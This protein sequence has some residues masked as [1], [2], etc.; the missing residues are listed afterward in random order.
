MR[1]TR[2]RSLIFPKIKQLLLL[3]ISWGYAETQS[4]QNKVTI[5]QIN[6]LYINDG[7]EYRFD[8]EFQ[9]DSSAVFNISF[10]PPMP[11]HNPPIKVKLFSP[12]TMAP[13]QILLTYSDQISCKDG[14]FLTPVEFIVFCRQNNGSQLIIGNLVRK[15]QAAIKQA[16]IVP[17]AEPGMTCRDPLV[18]VKNDFVTGIVY[19]FYIIPCFRDATGEAADLAATQFK[20]IY[21]DDHFKVIG[22]FSY[23]ASELSITKKGLNISD[24]EVI[25]LG[26]DVSLDE[27]GFNIP[28]DQLL[29]SI[30]LYSKKKGYFGNT[31]NLECVA[32]NIDYDSKILAIK[33]YKGSSVVINNQLKTLETPMVEIIKL[34][35][36]KVSGE[37]NLFYYMF[38]VN[39][40]PSN[41]IMIQA[42]RFLKN[43]GSNK[44]TLRA[45]NQPFSLM[46][47]VQSPYSELEFA[48]FSYP[49]LFYIDQNTLGTVSLKI[50]S[51][52]S[53]KKNKHS[54]SD[55]FSSTSDSEPEYN[56]SGPLTTLRSYYYKIVCDAYNKS[57]YDF[58]RL[59][60]G[61]Q[62]L[63]LVYTH[64]SH[65]HRT[66]AVIVDRVGSNLISQNCM[67]SRMAGFTMFNG[68]SKLFIKT[69]L[70]SIVEAY[71]LSSGSIVVIAKN[72]T[73]DQIV[74][75][76]ITQESR[77][78]Q[79]KSIELQFTVT[80]HAYT[81][82]KIDMNQTTMDVF[83]DSWTQIPIE[84]D[85]LFG[86]DARIS[87]EGL[88]YPQTSVILMQ[89]GQIECSFSSSRGRGPGGIL[90]TRNIKYMQILTSS[91][92]LAST[93]GR[94]GVFRCDLED[95]RLMSTLCTCSLILTK[96]I[97]DSKYAIYGELFHKKFLAVAVSNKP[98][99]PRTSKIFI[100][101]LETKQSVLV[102]NNTG[103]DFL[104]ISNQKGRFLVLE[105]AKL[106]GV[107]MVRYNS[108]TDSDNFYSAMFKKKKL[109]NGTMYYQLSMFS[110][111]DF[112]EENL[113]SKNPQTR[114]H[115]IREVYGKSG[116]FMVAMKNSYNG[117][118]ILDFKV[119]TGYYC[120]ANF[121]A[122]GCLETLQMWR[123]PYLDSRLD[124]DIC[125]MSKDV[126]IIPRGYRAT[127]HGLTGRIY[128]YSIPYDKEPPMVASA[129]VM[130]GYPFKSI[131]KAILDAT[132]YGFLDTFQIL[133]QD[134][135]GKK[136]IIS[137]RNSMDPRSR[138]SRIDM[139]NN[140]GIN[141]V[142]I[143]GEYE[144]KFV[145][146]LP[147][148]NTATDSKTGM[149]LRGNSWTFL[150]ER[151]DR[152][153]FFFTNYLQKNFFINLVLG[154]A[155]STDPSQIVKKKINVRGF[156]SNDTTNIEVNRDFAINLGV[157]F[158]A[159]AKLSKAMRKINETPKPLG[160]IKYDLEKRGV[161]NIT[162]HYFRSVLVRWSPKT[163]K[164][165]PLGFPENST[166]V[167]NTML[168]L[169]DKVSL[170]KVILDKSRILGISAVKDW[171]MLL[172]DD[173][174]VSIA[175]LT[176]SL[177]ID[178]KQGMS[179][180]LNSRY[181]KLMYDESLE[182]YFGVIL[183]REALGDQILIIAF[184]NNTQSLKAKDAYSTQLINLPENYFK[185]NI[186]NCPKSP[187]F[188]IVLQAT[189]KGSETIIPYL[190]QIDNTSTGGFTIRKSFYIVRQIKFDNPAKDYSS[191]CTPDFEGQSPILF[192]V[193]MF[194]GSGL[195]TTVRFHILPLKVVVINNVKILPDSPTSSLLP[196]NIAFLRTNHTAKMSAHGNPILSLFVITSGTSDYMFDVEVNIRGNIDK[197]II[198]NT[199]LDYMTPK[200]KSFIPK[201]LITYENYIMLTGKN[202]GDMRLHPANKLYELLVFDIRKRSIVGSFAMSSQNLQKESM[203]SI[204]AGVIDMNDTLNI[205][206]LE[207]YELKSNA[208]LNVFSR[209]KI[210]LIQNMSLEIDYDMIIKE[211]P[212]E[213]VRQDGGALRRL[214][215]R[216]G[217]LTRA[218]STSD[219]LA[220]TP[221]LRASTGANSPTSTSSAP[222]SPSGSSS[223]TGRG[224]E[225]QYLYP[226]TYRL[227]SYGL[228]N[229]VSQNMSLQMII[230]RG[231]SD[232]T[233]LEMI[234]AFLLELFLILVVI[235]VSTG[236]L[237]FICVI[238]MRNKMEESIRSNEGKV[239]VKKFKKRMRRRRLNGSKEHY[240]IIGHL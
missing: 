69:A 198:N 144:R 101:D 22:N 155:N 177:D 204:A 94:L 187:I 119:R 62:Y 118:M 127:S 81:G 131:S 13:R 24:F 113:W 107:I 162:G 6:R 89:G 179:F 143:H 233:L 137:Y 146:L 76:T 180:P 147:Y 166:D 88:E 138:V 176:G 202:M 121:G 188:V 15:K 4:I 5:D 148:L 14:Y 115:S 51:A 132:C 46:P 152:E 229:A 122:Y 171:A 142:G 141:A 90:F 183:I 182:T 99:G 165:E 102:N 33:A 231:R 228:D 128:V 145:L 197:V 225:P 31:S 199:K 203:I 140:T 154:K 181:I 63:M 8:E 50:Y 123:L 26:R 164:F 110:Q 93:R 65:R 135:Q 158:K 42:V 178:L 61:P 189:N 58:F 208:F 159:Y 70:K 44:V 195:F 23:N 60:A 240:K 59:Y 139:L 10:S 201:N 169:E 170:Q 174:S 29:G 16:L 114:V 168:R 1:S 74:N 200:V 3:G 92:V 217:P 126:A 30:C 2:V 163:S 109:R 72:T 124:V 130:Q 27:L 190:A 55:P 151:S 28:K 97:P 167:A 100:L 49:D 211:R 47:D 9:R 66:L 156:E 111:M 41:K 73:N 87:I 213:Y 79:S 117:Q 57:N 237:C 136:R 67:L 235:F 17:G 149:T 53:N 227:I 80:D 20:L 236:C 54:A 173:Y 21:T 210:Y 212:P 7:V 218:L 32:V 206:T 209:V 214:L 40:S 68:V 105:F 35:N 25:G 193:V 104:E 64:K 48:G 82:Y 98:E 153:V 34:V 83:I 234:V 103:T 96:I 232:P 221:G 219:P 160:K 192:Q 207:R 120:V 85:D 108:T 78:Y 175:P 91:V 36:P 223:S 226:E 84:R 11:T 205:F 216:A 150:Y 71:E 238:R 133:I 12:I 45:V 161:L 38:Y 116:E 220:P 230:R 18:M 86:N 191:R 112:L 125:P 129:Y 196:M 134:F 194:R 184:K 239:M 19:H 39:A 215:A 37:N 106:V 56:G 222:L 224:I 95:L 77:Y 157:V 185:V 186:Y 172:M 52:G 75:V 43:P